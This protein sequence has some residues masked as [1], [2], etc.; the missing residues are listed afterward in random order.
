M[1]LSLFRFSSFIFYFAFGVCVCLCFLSFP[2]ISGKVNIF[3]CLSC[4]K[5][6]RRRR[7][8]GRETQGNSLQL[9]MRVSP[10]SADK[11]CLLACWQRALLPFE[12]F[13][14]VLPTYEGEVA[15]PRVGGQISLRCYRIFRLSP[16]ALS[17]LSVSSPPPTPAPWAVRKISLSG[18]HITF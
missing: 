10:V 12:P 17:A 13:Q 5:F 3:W 6:L 1:S 11:H 9:I 7:R 18:H 16:R 8:S 2:F 4:R 14:K 15:R